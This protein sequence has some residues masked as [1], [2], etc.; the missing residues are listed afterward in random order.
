M[1]DYRFRIV[2]AEALPRTY[3][4]E[5]IAW[6]SVRV[7]SSAAN[8]IRIDWPRLLMYRKSAVQTRAYLSVHALLDRSAHRGQPVTREIF[9]PVL[10]RNGRPKRGPGGRIARTERLVENPLA[11]YAPFLPDQHL[12]GFLGMSNTAKNRHDC[13]GAIENLNCDKVVELVRERGGYR[14]YGPSPGWW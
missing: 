9:E 8:G 14:V 4:R 10:D 5:A 12:A 1:G 3:K 2:V 11:C 7:P 6:F 13:K